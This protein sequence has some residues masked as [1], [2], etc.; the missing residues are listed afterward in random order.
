MKISTPI[1]GESSKPVT[2]DV[3]MKVEPKSQV[4]TDDNDSGDDGKKTKDKNTISRKRVLSTDEPKLA[5]G[6]TDGTHQEKKL[7]TEH[8]SPSQ[9]D[10]SSSTTG[11]CDVNANEEAVAD[12][13]KISELKN[14]LNLLNDGNTKDPKLLNS[15]ETIIGT[16]KFLALK[17]LFAQNSAFETST[18]GET[19]NSE[20]NVD[21]S[22]ANGSSPS[23]LKELLTNDV[24][25]ETESQF[26]KKKI[27]RYQGILCMLDVA[28]FDVTATVVSE[29]NYDIVKHMPSHIEVVGRIKP[30]FVCDYL[31]TEKRMP[32]KK[33]LVLRFAATDEMKYSEFFNY[34]HSKGQYGVVKV[35]TETIKDFYL[36]TVKADEEVPEVLLPFTGDC[37][38]EGDLQRPDSILGVILMTTQED[39]KAKDSEPTAKKVLENSN[40]EDDGDAPPKK[41]IKKAPPV[42]RHRKTEADKLNQDIMQMFIRDDVL[43]AQGLR[44]R[45]TLIYDEDNALQALQDYELDA[46]CSDNSDNNPSKKTKTAVDPPMNPTVNGIEKESSEAPAESKLPQDYTSMVK[47]CVVELEFIDFNLLE[48]PLRVNENGELKPKNLEQK[49]VPQIPKLIPIEELNKLAASQGQ[50]SWSFRNGLPNLPSGLLVKLPDYVASDEIIEILDDD[51]QTVT[52]QSVTAPPKT[53]PKR[54]NTD[55]F[56]SEV[57]SL[58]SS[59]SSK[60]IS[61]M[62]KKVSNLSYIQSRNGLTFKCNCEKCGF[63][64]LNM[65]LF[66]YH[67]QSR[68]VMVKWSGF[69]L[70]CKKSVSNFGSVFDEFTHMYKVHTRKDLGITS[71]SPARQSDMKLKRG[72]PKKQIDPPVLKTLQSKPHLT[73][74][75]ISAATATKTKLAQDLKMSITVSKVKSPPPP[76]YQDSSSSVPSSSVPALGTDPITIKFKNLPGDKLSIVKATSLT[77]NGHDLNLLEKLSTPVTKQAPQVIQASPHM[78][79][80]LKQ[81]LVT[82]SP[83]QKIIAKPSPNFPSVMRVV[84][85]PAASRAEATS[86]S[87][88]TSQ[89]ALSGSSKISSTKYVFVNSRNE[90]STMEMEI[91]KRQ[92]RPWL[93]GSDCKKERA[94]VAMLQNKCLYD[95]YKCMGKDCEYTTND[96]AQFS[97]HQQDHKKSQQHDSNIYGR[98]PYCNFVA[99]ITS[100]LIMHIRHDHMLEGFAC[101]FCF[102]RAITEF[103]VILHTRLHHKN[104]KNGKILAIGSKPVLDRK[105]T[106]SW[107]RLSMIKFIHGITCAC[108]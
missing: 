15:F 73:V 20:A 40:H 8:S 34:L 1:V 67:I 43:K 56:I 79:T 74:E 55:F 7:R 24:K 39:G 82:S 32:G 37:L 96:S 103:N 77:Q 25:M 70:I 107:A 68:H 83:T 48:L 100:N 63:E 38:V 88:I 58:Q 101:N 89:Q 45:K 62:E 92:L 47:D 10:S 57:A 72:R 41:I 29:D 44:T 95:L 23:S 50:T 17:A 4:D 86:S 36:F 99:N 66:Q 52:A 22:S 16:K 85:V 61:G 51:E 30:A 94:V 14:L 35:A 11:S 42:K 87:P 106:V 78:N 9:H 2:S 81:A 105:G 26:E 108:K 75:R 60:L 76:P 21:H 12:D 33:L 80:L 91:G 98:C 46:E 93:S 5:A 31:D 59:P 71:E 65:E 49:F 69:C 19:E 64:T 90:V 54:E 53:S 6:I 18:V 104:L 28:R 3:E 97:K 102:Y 27:E 13:E 84:K